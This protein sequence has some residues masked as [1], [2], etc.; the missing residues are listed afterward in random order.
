MNDNN[1]D[2]NVIE[3]SAGGGLL[4]GIC[5]FFAALSAISAVLGFLGMV[6]SVLLF[7]VGPA[8]LF[9]L[10]AGWSMAW[11]GVWFCVGRKA[12]KQ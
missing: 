1:N 3:I 2:I 7:G 6:V 4:S 10:W 5:G 8:L 9:F 12:E 11:F